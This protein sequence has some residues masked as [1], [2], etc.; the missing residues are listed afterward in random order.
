MVEG[1]KGVEETLKS[2]LKV[3]FL[4]LT[5]AFAQQ[6]D[7]DLSEVGE[8]EEVSEKELISA[9][10]FSS[11]N[12]GLAVVQIPE[13]GFEMPQNGLIVALD[14]VQDPGNLG[15]IIRICDWYGVANLLCSKDT[16]D[17]YNP[18]VINATMGSFSRIKMQYVDLEKVLKD[19]PLP[20]YGA[21]LNGK[22]IYKADLKKEAIIVMGNESKGLSE[23]IEA[24]IDS[25]ILIPRVGEAESLN[26]GVAT[27][28]V[29]DNF[30]R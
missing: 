6:L 30:V 1:A 22:S 4:L 14:R 8:V 20:K 27:A 7:A 15:T 17:L 12:A 10:T 29:L 13:V 11:N 21:V 24:L 3:A 19:S 2:D 18:K 5:K 26:V 25:P 9:G 28:I 23:E 16:A